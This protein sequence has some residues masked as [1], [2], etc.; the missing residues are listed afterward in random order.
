MEQGKG[1]GLPWTG[2]AAWGADAEAWAL[3]CPPPRFSADPGLL[4]CTAC[5]GWS[6]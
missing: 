6:V 2:G 3:L 5:L 4:A 1:W